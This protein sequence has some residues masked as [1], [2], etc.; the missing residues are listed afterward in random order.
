MS[1]VRPGIH[2]LTR[3]QCALVHE[4]SLKILR[5]VGIRVDSTAARAIFARAGCRATPEH[6]I[7]VPAEQIQWA[8]DQAPGIIDIYARRAG[9]S[10][11]AFTLGKQADR[12][13]RFGMGVTNLYWQ[14]PETDAI[15]PF[16]I[17]HVTVAA[18]LAQLGRGG[19]RSTNSGYLGDLTRNSGSD[20]VE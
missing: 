7:H 19:G 3:D 13:T 2:C 1:S 10:N 5:E 9:D 6:R 14:E 18:R 16:S 8:I 11:P 4:H 15:V 20:R 12:S 17:K